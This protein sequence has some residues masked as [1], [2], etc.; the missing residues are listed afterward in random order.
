MSKTIFKYP[1]EVVETQNLVMP[2]SAQILKLGVQDDK[3]YVW[4]LIEEGD[5]SVRSQEIK[6]VGTGWE[7]DVDW[8]NH[9]GTVFVRRYVW[10]YFKA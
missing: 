4:A 9:I 8:E 10:H 5:N 7:T 1:L 6:M 3:V 2:N